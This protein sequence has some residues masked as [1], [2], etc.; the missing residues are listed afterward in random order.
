MG[1]QRKKKS[2]SDENK[3][4]NLTKKKILWIA[5]HTQFSR[6]RKEVLK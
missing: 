3:R 1:Q 4:R 6:R 5:M 2:D